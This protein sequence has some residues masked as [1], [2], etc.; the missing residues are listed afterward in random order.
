MSVGNIISKA[1][2]VGSLAIIGYE[3][4]ANSR[5]EARQKTIEEDTNLL[6]DVFVNKQTSGYSGTIIEKL[7]TLFANATLDSKI[8]KSLLTIKNTITSF[9]ENTVSSIVPIGLGIGALLTGKQ[10]NNNTKLFSR[11]P[12]II[13]KVC[14]GLLIANGL[15]TVTTDV[16][17]LGEKSDL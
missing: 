15:M 10:L 1:I 11:I 13:G 17:G 7:K 14:A 3:I 5:R 12:P 6:T 9:I 4:T 8:W 2:G 16:L